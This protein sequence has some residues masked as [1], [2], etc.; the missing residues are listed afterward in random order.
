MTNTW[1]LTLEGDRSDPELSRLQADSDLQDV[2]PQ[3]VLQAQPL[4]RSRLWSGLGKYVIPLIEIVV[5]VGLWQ[6]VTA[7][8]IISPL[9]IAQPS[10][11]ARV[12]WE[13]FVTQRYIYEDLLT[14]GQEFILGFVLGSTIGISL[15]L[16]MGLSGRIKRILDPLV[17][18]LYAVPQVAFLS[19]LIIWFGI[20]MKP[21]VFLIFVGVV[22]TLVIN[23]EAGVRNVDP[24]LMDMSRAFGKSTGETLRKVVI[25]GSFPFVL[26]G[27]RLAVG[28]SLIMLVVAEMYAANHGIGY[29]IM[30]AGS[31]YNTPVLVMGVIV[32][33][34]ISVI[35]SSALKRAER[36]VNSWRA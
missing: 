22:F 21:K 31:S 7:L 17:M 30:N 19:L 13:A 33:S 10:S 14:S 1:K 32:L 9:E 12:F 24:T 5:I 16:A 20:G 27:L 8:K 3:G 6:G 35:A 23:T 2:T 26:A 34:V 15:G 18:F 25:P 11:V 29:L 36:R 4:R 28:R